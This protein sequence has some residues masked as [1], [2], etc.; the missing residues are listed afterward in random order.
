MVSGRVFN[1]PFKSV[2]AD[3]HATV[4]NSEHLS[5]GLVYGFFAAPTGHGLCHCI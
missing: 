1:I 2:T 5:V 3:E 4:N